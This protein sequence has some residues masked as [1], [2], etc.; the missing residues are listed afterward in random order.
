MIFFKTINNQTLSQKNMIYV[1]KSTV[2]V[3]SYRLLFDLVQISGVEKCY[4]SNFLTQLALYN[5]E[6]LDIEYTK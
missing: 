1:K 3:C 4:V 6:Y 2:L 5:E